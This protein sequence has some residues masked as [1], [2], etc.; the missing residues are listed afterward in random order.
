VD[1]KSRLVDKKLGREKHEI[2]EEIVH[3]EEI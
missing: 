1:A 3:S 2:Y